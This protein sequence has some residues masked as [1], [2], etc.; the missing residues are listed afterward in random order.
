MALDLDKQKNFFFIKNGRNYT[1]FKPGL[2]EKLF[3]P[4]MIKISQNVICTIL[5]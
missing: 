5:L 4:G 3:H 1:S 2:F